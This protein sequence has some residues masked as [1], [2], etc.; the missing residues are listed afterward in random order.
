MMIPKKMMIFRR[1]LTY[2]NFM[3]ETYSQPM[4]LLR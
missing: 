2:V 4:R 1:F 3:P